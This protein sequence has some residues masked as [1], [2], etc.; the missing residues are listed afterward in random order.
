MLEL[1]MPNSETHNLSEAILKISATEN[2]QRPKIKISYDSV[3][4]C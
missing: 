3:S 1:K 2:V 4:I